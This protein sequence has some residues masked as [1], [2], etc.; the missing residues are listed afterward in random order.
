M[1]SNHRYPAK[2]FWPPVDPRAI[3]LPQQ[4]SAVSCQGPMVRIH[5]PPADSL[6]LSRSRFRRSRTRLSARVWAA[7]LPT[8]QQRLAGCFDIASTG[9]NISVGPYSSTAVRLVVA[10]GLTRGRSVDFKFGSGSSKAEHD[11]LIVPGKRQTGMLEQL[12]CRQIGWLPPIEDRLGD[13]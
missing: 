11:P 8:G 7:G 1:D 6:S 13:S 4:K 9:G 5:L 10:P 2:F 12:L 3:H